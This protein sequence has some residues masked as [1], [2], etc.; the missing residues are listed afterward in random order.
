LARIDV[1]NEHPVPTTAHNFKLT[2]CIGGKTYGGQYLPMPHGAFV[3]DSRND[4]FTNPDKIADFASDIA[5]RPLIQGVG[6]QNL[7]IRFKVGGLERIEEGPDTGQ[8]ELEIT[9]A[10]RQKHALTSERPLRLQLRDLTFP[11]MAR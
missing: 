6:R 7:W 4:L 8:I 1:V 10:F 2:M 11:R 9:D 5:D 3:F